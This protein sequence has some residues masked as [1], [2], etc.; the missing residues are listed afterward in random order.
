MTILIVDDSRAM[1]MLIMRAVR[2]AGFRDHTMIEAANG[3]EALAQ[4]ASHDPDVIISDWNMP[5][6]SGFDL[7]EELNRQ[8]SRAKFGFVTSESTE[9]MRTRAME[10]GAVFVIVKPFSTE[11]FQYTLEQVIG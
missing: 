8:K 10:A 11:E 1:R 9:E 7:L 4:V 5:V 2:Q 3:K 6:M